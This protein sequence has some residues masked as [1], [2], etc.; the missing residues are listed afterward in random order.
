MV[1]YLW[2]MWMND[3][4][5]IVFLLMPGLMDGFCFCARGFLPPKMFFSTISVGS[6]EIEET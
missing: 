6:L 2:V 4:C 3:S 5:Y 1:P